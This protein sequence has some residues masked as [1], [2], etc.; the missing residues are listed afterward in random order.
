MLSTALGI[1]IGL[2]FAIPLT[3]IPTRIYLK[4]ATEKA[5]YT[6]ILPPIALIYIGFSFYYQDLA[7]LPSEIF[8]V[9]IFTGF[10]LFSRFF[11]SS[12]LAL[13]YISHGLWDLSHELFQPGIVEY[14]PW[15]QVPIGYAAF[16]LTYDFIVAIYILKRRQLW[17]GSR[18]AWM[19]TCS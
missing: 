11:G 15:T 5:F 7:V 6:W 17:D 4:P 1:I 18:L 12:W 9:S 10:A 2:I 13:G 8:G 3:I 19:T 14:I 16:C